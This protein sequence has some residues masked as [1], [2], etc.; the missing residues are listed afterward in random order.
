MRRWIILACATLLAAGAALAQTGPERPIESAPPAAKRPAPGATSH[1][2]TD[3]ERAARLAEMEQ[4]I[5][6]QNDA[7]SPPAVSAGQEKPAAK[8]AP[9]KGAKP[10]AAPA[11]DPAIEAQRRA[12]WERE[13]RAELVREWSM[14]AAVVA[15]YVALCFGLG[16]AARQQGRQMSSY[17]LLGLLTTPVFGL[18]VLAIAGPDRAVQDARS[19]ER[20]E[21]PRCGEWIRNRAFQCRFCGAELRHPYR[22]SMQMPSR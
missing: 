13:H 12:A 3:A 16:L 17:V 5:R 10:T 19:G 6:R 11:P 20:I 4:S 7:L 22:A 21:C 15:V 2:Q 8:R 1:R 9:R 14:I 18:I